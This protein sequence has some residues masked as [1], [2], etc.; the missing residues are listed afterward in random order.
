[1]SDGMVT[2]WGTGKL[3][4][5]GEPSE[6]EVTAER[7]IA[8]AEGTNDEHPK[9]LSGE[10]ASPVFAFVPVFQ[11]LMPVIAQVVPTEILM[12]VVHGEH[13][14]SYAQPIVPG[15]RLVSRVAPVGIHGRSSGVTVIAKAVTET[16]SGEPVVE[17]YMTAFFRG[18][19]LDGSHGEEAPP[20]AFPEHLR[21]QPPLLSVTH[22]YDADQTQRY[23]KASGDPM[24]I[25][26]DDEFAKSV[27]LP[28]IIA[29]GMCTL[30]FASRAVI[31]AG[32]PDDPARLSRLAA[33]FGA[34]VQPS[35]QVTTNVYAGPPTLAF[36]TV[37]D[38]GNTAIK[39]GLAEVR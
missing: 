39:D 13:D 8:Y 6:F 9:H 3:G 19:E 35:E 7:T 37:S 17:Q 11:A 4:Q 18:A 24:P 32:C 22:G 30:A 21:E 33:R 34:I 36:E 23:S 28:G 16:S 12:R 25:H 26:L 38:N 10:L 31:A 1:M 27:G 15:M 2:E 29:H 5:W 14:F 20:H